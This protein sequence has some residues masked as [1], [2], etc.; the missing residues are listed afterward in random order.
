MADAELKRPREDTAPLTPDDLC[1]SAKKVA[2]AVVIIWS[3]LDA[4]QQAAVEDDL[5]GRDPSQRRSRRP[6]KADPR[7]P[8]PCVEL[9]VAKPSLVQQCHA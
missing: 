5:F 6:E 2:Q 8:P 7:A 9:V 1:Q 3:V 4:P